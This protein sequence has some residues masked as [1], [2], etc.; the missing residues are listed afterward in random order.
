MMRERATDPIEWRL[1][2]EALGAYWLSDR[3][4]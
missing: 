1:G 3:L 4:P 2:E